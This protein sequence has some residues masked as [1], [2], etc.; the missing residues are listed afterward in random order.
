MAGLNMAKCRKIIRAAFAK[1]K[2]MGISNVETHI[3]PKGDH[4]FFFK[5]SRV[6]NPLMMKFFKKHLVK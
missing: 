6:V 5:D 2:E 1:A 3:N 4:V